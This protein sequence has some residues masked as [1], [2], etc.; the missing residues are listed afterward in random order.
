MKTEQFGSWNFEL[1]QVF[2]RKTPVFGEPYTASAVITI[3]N[4]EP[5]IELLL[6][7]SDDEFC[8]QDLKDLKAFVT[9]LGFDKTKFVRV[10]STNN[11]HEH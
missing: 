4:G 3:V 7:K 9:S 8:K 10:K 6:N 2:A 5:N 1:K 11:I